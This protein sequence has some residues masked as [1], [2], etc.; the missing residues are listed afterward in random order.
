MILLIDFD[1]TL[2]DTDSLYREL[3]KL[4]TLPGKPDTLPEELVSPLLYE[5]SIT[6]LEEQKRA[7]T[8]ILITLALED[9]GPRVEE[10][11][12]KKVHASGLTKYFD[13]IELVVGVKKD[14]KI[15]ELVKEL[16]GEKVVYIDDNP[17]QL[18]AVSECCPSVTRFH[19]GR[20]GAKYENVVVDS[21]THT[22]SS[23]KEV[24]A[25]L[26]GL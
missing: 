4:G 25:K 15:E 21:N 18:K 7:H 6:F 5:D 12:Y 11:Q 19:I 16:E 26:R 20:P 14:R 24:S 10:F 1:R 9:Y 13:R 22:V 3:Q 2:L 23:L 8:L 17:D